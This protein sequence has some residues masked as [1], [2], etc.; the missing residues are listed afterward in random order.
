MVNIIADLHTHTLASGHGIDTIRTLS[1]FAIKKGLQ[2][3][4]ITDH[5]PG[6]PGGPDFIYFL[7]LKRM[8]QGIDLPIRIVYGVEDDIKNR[9]GEL[10]LS[11]DIHTNLEIVLT[12]IHP[13]TWIAQQEI[14][15]RTDAVINA[16]GRGIVRVFTHPVGTY[17]DVHIEP[18]I[19]AAAKHRVA[20]ELNA[21][22]L[23]EKKI[24]MD[25]LEKC[26]NLGA[27]IVVNS[28]AHLG[29]EVGR[30]TEALG[31]LREINFPK[32]LIINSSKKRIASFFGIDW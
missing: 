23:G 2:A 31:I 17:S 32:E 26:A 15:V 3:I 25:Y 27:S 28:D 13:F 24:V 19:T 10:A 16:I 7:S 12:G 8:T 21:T 5:G 14:T 9:K 18:V 29:E 22:K 6:M 20:M 30:V 1:E 4:A 11:E